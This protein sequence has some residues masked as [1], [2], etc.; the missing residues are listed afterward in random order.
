MEVLLLIDL[1]NDFCPGGSLPVP[2]GDK[3]IQI[4][5]ELLS[6]RH[7]DLV[8]AT[9]DWHPRNHGSFAINHPG[10]EEYSLGTL[11]GLPQRMWPAHCIENTWGAE[12]HP[13]LNTELIDHVVLKGTD[14]DIDSYSGFFDN[15]QKR[16]TNLREL[17][18]AEAKLRNVFRGDITID[19]M[20]LATEYCVKFTALDARRLDFDT[21]I[22]IDGCR[23]INQQPGDDL[24]TFRQLQQ[25]DIGV[26]DSKT[27][28]PGRTPAISLVAEL[29][30]QQQLQP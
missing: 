25:Q 29:E 30:R 17:I 12:F 24:K 26:I 14:P 13:D 6:S 4:A 28:F 19:C 11:G 21:N 27:I 5:N 22:I 2:D 3:T 23:G 7:Y 1:Q 8:I 15:G 16:E 20:G 10:A 18:E 9:K